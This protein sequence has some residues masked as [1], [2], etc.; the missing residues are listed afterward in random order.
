MMAKSALLAAALVG[1]F[2]AAPAAASRK[3]GSPWAGGDGWSP[4]MQTG[5]ARNPEIGI[6]NIDDL[7]AAPA[8][9]VQ[10]EAPRPELLERA[11]NPNTCGYIAG[12]TRR[13]SVPRSLRPIHAPIFGRAEHRLPAKVPGRR[14]R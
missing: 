14:V 4:A 7:M 9:P 2:S 13:S 8:P 10:T 3:R 5:L 11:L 1:L 12:P 6:E